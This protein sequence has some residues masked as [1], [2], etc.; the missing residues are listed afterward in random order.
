MAVQHRLMEKTG[1]L[2]V[3][4]SLPQVNGASLLPGKIPSIM[5]EP[6]TIGTTR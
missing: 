3:S 2:F 5:Y 4:V 6:S 1:R